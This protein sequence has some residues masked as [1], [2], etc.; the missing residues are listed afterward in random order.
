M[1]VQERRDGADP[2]VGDDFGKDVT[3]DVTVR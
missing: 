2:I 3:K 1:D